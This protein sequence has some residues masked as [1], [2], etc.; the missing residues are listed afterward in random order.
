[1]GFDFLSFSHVALLSVPKYLWIKPWYFLLLGSFWSGYENAA[2]RNTQTLI[3]VCAKNLLQPAYQSSKICLARLPPQVLCIPILPWSF[4]KGSTADSR[5]PVSVE[6]RLSANPWLTSTYEPELCHMA[7]SATK[8]SFQREHDTC[9]RESV[10]S[11]GRWLGQKKG[12]NPRVSSSLQ[13]PDAL[14]VL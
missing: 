5:K 9:R 7:T 2:F 11:Q 14:N 1:M 8:V 10:G 13:T 12:E 6:Q 4:K 3:C